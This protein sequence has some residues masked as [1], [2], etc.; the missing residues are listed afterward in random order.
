MCAHA[1]EANSII[2]RF[3][4]TLLL[5]QALS[6]EAFAAVVCRHLREHLLQRTQRSF[7]ERIL[8]LALQYSASIPLQFLQLVLPQGV[9]E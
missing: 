4:C 1:R 9:R 6:E 5:L 3:H 8:G 7:D 2:P